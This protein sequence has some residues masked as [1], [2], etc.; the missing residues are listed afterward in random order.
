MV[1]AAVSG[2]VALDEAIAL[3]I[4]F[5]R[6]L[7]GTCPRRD[8]YGRPSLDSQAGTSVG[9][10]ATNELVLPLYS[11][12]RGTNTAQLFGIEEAFASALHVRP[13]PGR[14]ILVLAGQDLPVDGLR[15]HDRRERDHPIRLDR[16][17]VADLGVERRDF[18]GRY[19]V[20]EL[21]TDRRKQEP[22]R[23]GLI[24]IGAPW[25]FCLRA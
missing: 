25:L 12:Q 9:E 13:D 15:E 3:D 21:F 6:R 17:L 8:G 7:P 22:I 18:D 4:P 5:T 19:L 23:I 1:D 16:S 24:A 11:V 20:Q 14:W 2:H 10:F